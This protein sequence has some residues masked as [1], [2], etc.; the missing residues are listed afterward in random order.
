MAQVS[1]VERSK[2]HTLYRVSDEGMLP[3]TYIICT[4]TAREVL[5][6]PH[7]VGKQLQDCMEK[8]SAVFAEILSKRVLSGVKRE[9]VCELIFLSGGL[10]YALNF[11]FKKN[12]G[13]ALQQCFI[14]IQ[15]QRVESKAGQNRNFS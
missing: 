12:F 10:Y 4:E 3:D 2:S 9:N 1:E 11:G 15:R 7:M 13:F 5:Y 8:N 14:G 6:S